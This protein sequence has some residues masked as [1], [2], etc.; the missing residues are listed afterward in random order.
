MLVLVPTIQSPGR[1]QELRH[2]DGR[3]HEVRSG[4][5]REEGEGLQDRSAAGGRRQIR[6]PPGGD[7]DVGDQRQVPRRRQAAAAAAERGR[8]GV[9][10][11]DE[12][13]SRRHLPRC[14]PASIGR[15]PRTRPRTPRCSSR[16]SPTPKRSSSRRSRTRPCG[17]PNARKQVETIQAAVTAGKWD[18]AKTNA[19]TLQQACGQ[20]HGLPRALR[21]RVVRYKV[22]GRTQ[23][24]GA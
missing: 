22:A 2:R 11:G 7:R 9:P 17:R 20:C 21:R 24:V 19:G 15:T 6:G 4:R 18:E 13:A 14:A 10:E 12:A 1:S 3:G 23:V 5:G 8:G 16:P